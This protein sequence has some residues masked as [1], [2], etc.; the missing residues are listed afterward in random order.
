MTP[1]DSEFIDDIVQ[2]KVPVHSETVRDKFLPWH[3]VRKEYIRRRQWNELTGRMVRGL[4]RRQLDLP[5]EWTLE[6][7]SVAE[8][9][10]KIPRDVRLEKTLKCLVIPG[11]DL[12]DVRALWEDVQQYKCEIRYLGFNESQGSDRKNTRLYISNNAVISLPYVSTDSQVVHDRFEAIAN[13]QSQAIRYLKEYGPYHVVN[14][15]LCGTMFPNVRTDVAPYYAALHQLLA[16][17]FRSQTSPWLLFVTTVVEPG[18]VNEAE[19]NKLC[20]PARQNFD[21]YPDF[22]DEVKK[23]IPEQAFRGSATA[24]NLSA[25][26]GDQ[27]TALFGVAL[28]KWL[29]GLCQQASP[30]WTFAMRR[31]FRYSQNEPKGASMLS[32]AFELKPNIAPPVDSVG[33]SGLKLHAITYPDE[34]QCAVQLAKSVANIRDVDAHLSSDLSL[35]E[36]LKNTKAALLESAGY[37]RDAFIT[38]VDKGEVD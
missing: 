2:D 34:R 3:R 17:Q 25:L 7:E 21:K 20:G 12:L 1:Q 35:K 29:L 14:L 10:I 19:F 30:Q 37:N 11:E 4:W 15:D 24:I 23:K 38:W 13:D 32:L 18:V 8:Q 31:S 27:M 26:T 36:E 22:A 16:Y 6:G 5:E 33:M 28:G 9:S